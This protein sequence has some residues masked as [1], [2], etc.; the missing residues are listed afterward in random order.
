[1]VVMYYGTPSQGSNV[2]IVQKMSCSLTEANCL[3]GNTMCMY[4]RKCSTGEGVLWT[5]TCMT[6]DGALKR[7]IRIERWEPRGG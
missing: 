3:K 1:M 4:E 5:T 6:E 2:T 7:V